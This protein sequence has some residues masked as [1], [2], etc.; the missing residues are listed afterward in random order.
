[1]SE[2]T[3]PSNDALYAL[4]P[5]FHRMRDEALGGPL[6][7]LLEVIGEQ[8][9]LLE[10]DIARLYANCFIETCDDWAVPYIGDLVGY[11]PVLEAG[12]P[13]ARGS[14][15]ARNR[16]AMPRREIANTIALRRRKGTLALLELLAR[17]V[18]GWPARAVEFYKLLGWTQHLNFQ[19]LGRGRTVDLR[20]GDALD[21]LDGAFDSIAHTVDI[22]R[23]GSPL[24][25]GRYAIASVGLFV[26]NMRSLSVT[27]T[28]ACLQEGKGGRRYSFSVLGADTRLY[29]LPLEQQ[30]PDEI[31][32]EQNL[33]LPIRR[34]ALRDPDGHVAAAYYGPGK[35]LSVSAVDWPRKDAPQ[36]IP[37]ELVVVADLSDWSRYKAPRGVVS[38]DP[39]L[40]RIAFPDNAPPSRGVRVS[41]H[42]GFSAFMGG[43]E[44]PR[45]LHAPAGA[46]VYRVG[47]KEQIRSIN[48]ALAMW[49]V[50]KKNSG[51]RAAVIEITD[52]D[53]Y[54]EAL[55]VQ[56][57]AGESLQIRAAN[58]RRPVLRLLD[59]VA[60]GD[61]AFSIRGA[62]ASR[63]VLDGLLVTGR[64]LRVA[65]PGMQDD[66]GCDGEQGELCDLRI[67]HCTL[68]PGWG[69]GC[70]CD[71]DK[72]NEPSIELV[73][74][75]AALVIEHS[76]VGTILVT[77][78]EVTRDPGVIDISDSILD[79]TGAELIALAASDQRLAFAD[80]RLA[81][82]TVIGEVRTHSIT[83][84]ENSI[85]MGVANVARRQLG[86]IRFS[87]VTPDSRTPR[88]FRCQP[89]LVAAA[90]AVPDRPGEQQRVAPRFTSLRYGNP[91]YCQLHLRC[92]PEIAGGADD[93]S[94]M[95][96]FHDLYQPQ[97]SANLRTR[98]AEYT[99]AATQ[100]GLIY[101]N[102][103]T[104]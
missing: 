32:G 41:Y 53:V 63:M 33:P 67:R 18:A 65:G 10:A 56:L 55:N 58:L 57:E 43:G 70:D 31:A 66:C 79:A 17:D 49:Q 102:Q 73:D 91:G 22:R 25:A 98:L 74:T 52:S 71:P 78:N 36:P 27:Q 97:R 69:L 40:G 28:P 34:R 47:H 5:A 26:Y 75:Q 84:A 101:G 85:L 20:A 87:Y 83:L 39:V 44:Y 93:E 82:C 95:G 99:P 86:C 24:H 89:D 77:A 104:P 14:P 6:R 11:R 96:A 54:T 59:Q 30:D 21:R 16:I 72:P 29:T 80:L 90:A 94:E 13:A 76:I 48:A 100:A 1:M 15:A 50:E 51:R 2:P 46:L 60:D 8:A 4:L 37:R 19:H 35:S 92:A 88:R 38:L 45:A 23:P 61:D 3:A 9:G 81:R 103:E 42:Y 12:D 64:G 62:R 7:E 68:V